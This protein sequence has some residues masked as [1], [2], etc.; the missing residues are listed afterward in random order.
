MDLLYR[1]IQNTCDGCEYTTT[2]QAIECTDENNDIVKLRAR[3]FSPSNMTEQILNSIKSWITHTRSIEVQ[4]IRLHLESNCSLVI[5]SLESPIYCYQTSILTI[6]QPVTP[7]LNHNDSTAI[8]T[9]H[10]LRKPNNNISLID[11]IIISVAV[12]VFGLIF[13]AGVLLIIITGVYK[14]SKYYK[15]RQ[16]TNK[17]SHVKTSE[18]ETCDDCVS[19]IGSKQCVE[20]TVKNLEHHSGS[21]RGT[22]SDSTSD[23]GDNPIIHNYCTMTM[24]TT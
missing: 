18:A 1:S 7:I 17:L 12:A 22:P 19:T 16:P 6:S 11:A 14:V 9:T 20:E 2:N 21:D 4:G 8:I 10:R 5:E 24:N 23:Y 15:T 13:V 3:L